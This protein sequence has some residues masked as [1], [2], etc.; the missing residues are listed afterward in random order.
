MVKDCRTSWGVGLGGTEHCKRLLV[1][2]D[3]SKEIVMTHHIRYG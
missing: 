3:N 2:T 1:G